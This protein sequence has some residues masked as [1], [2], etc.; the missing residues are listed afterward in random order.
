MRVP[1]RRKTAVVFLVLG[2]VM[3]VIAVTLNVGW[4]LLNLQQIA[5]LVFGVIFFAIIITGLVL[6]TTFLLRE[7]RRNEQQDAFLNAVTHEL[8]TPIASIKLYLETLKTREVEDAKRSE[9]YDIMLSDSNR[10]L[11]T[12]E[13]VLQAGRTK[14]KARL[15]NISEIE[16][17]ELLKDCVE[18]IRSRYNLENE[19][20]IKETSEKLIVSGDWAELQTVFTNLIDNAVK[21]S[22]EKI[23]IS[24]ILNDLNEKII[25]ICI[26]DSGVGIASKELKSVFKRFYRVPNLSTQKAKGTGLGLYIARA[27]IKKHD[28]KIYAQSE[29]EGK[30]TT[31]TVRL[32]KAEKKKLSD[33]N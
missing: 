3:I 33:K 17:G 30:G 15:L 18:I 10:L 22:D 24:V 8:K 25:E 12:V 20:T 13:Q 14:D 21:Y 11:T 1:G 27:V 16:L 2:I 28:G 29:G 5:L 32:P 7:I 4:I 26:K 9:F 31:F 6:N 23:K 19:I